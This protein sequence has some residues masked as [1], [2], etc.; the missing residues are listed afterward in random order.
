MYMYYSLCTRYTDRCILGYHVAIML[1]RGGY[2]L[3]TIYVAHAYWLVRC[4]CTCLIVISSND[5]THMTIL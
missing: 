3:I 4:I 5:S 1:G 2:D